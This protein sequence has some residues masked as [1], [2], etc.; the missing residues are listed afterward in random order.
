MSCFAF[1]PLPP[2]GLTATWNGA[3]IDL[4]WTDNSAASPTF[5]LTRTDGQNHH[6]VTLI[7]AGDAA[8]VDATAVELTDYT[9]SLRAID[10]NVASAATTVA[11]TGALF[12]PTGLTAVA[13]SP[14]RI[15]LAWTNNTLVSTTQKADI[16]ECNSVKHS[17]LTALFFRRLRSSDR[18]RFI[19]SYCLARLLTTRGS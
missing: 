11:V 10:N 18:G 8:Y 12:N 15:D 19:R 4:A 3:E 6:V 9:Y 2:A 1:P 17:H 13:V 14:T 7:P 5:Q 16:P